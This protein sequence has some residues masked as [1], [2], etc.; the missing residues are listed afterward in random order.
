MTT[1]TVRERLYRKLFHKYNRV[2]IPILDHDKPL[3]VE[4]GLS[5]LHFEVDTESHLL[6]VNTH[7]KQSWTDYRLIW[8]PEEYEGIKSIVVT[9]DDIWLPDIALF[10]SYTTNFF[11][12]HPVNIVLQS[13]GTIIWVTP[14]R[15]QVY[16]RDFIQH[17][18][19]SFTLKF[20]SWSYISSELD[21]T[22]FG[23]LESMEVTDYEGHHDWN[24]LNNTAVREENYHPCCPDPFIQFNFHLTVAKS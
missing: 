15:F 21:F 10:N 14:C 9:E 5:L 18:P 20:G 7:S 6:T 4:F 16:S 2:V 19:S 11:T 22:F 24:L 17:I 12:H 13:S 23:G 8:N 1:S 3:K